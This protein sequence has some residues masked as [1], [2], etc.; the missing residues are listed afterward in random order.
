MPLHL[1]VDPKDRL[2]NALDVYDKDVRTF[3]EYG[4]FDNLKDDS[5]AKRM[6]VHRIQVG[7]GSSWCSWMKFVA[8]YPIKFVRK[9][10]ICVPTKDEGMFIPVPPSLHLVSAYAEA[11][12][13]IGQLDLSRKMRL[14]STSNHSHVFLAPLTLPAP[15]L[16]GEVVVKMAKDNCRDRDMLKHEAMIYDKFPCELMQSTPSSLPVVPKFFGYYVPSCDSADSYEDENG[17]EE[18]AKIVRRDSRQWLQDAI[19]PIL[20]LEA[21]GKPIDADTLPS[22]DR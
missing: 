16:R 18:D 9:Y 12:R 11:H 5:D 21:C 14:G 15:S 2:P 10:P 13:L 20:L 19:S 1:Q 6:N 17:D 7:I 3:L 22:S 8:R 4:I